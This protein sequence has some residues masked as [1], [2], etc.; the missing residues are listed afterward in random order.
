[1]GVARAR[2]PP[3]PPCNTARKSR[4]PLKSRRSASLPSPQRRAVDGSQ[5]HVERGVFVSQLS[6]AIRRLRVGAR[7]LE[8]SRIACTSEDFIFRREETARLQ[9]ASIHA[10]T[11][12]TDSRRIFYP[13]TGN[14]FRVLGLLAG[15]RGIGASTRLPMSSVLI[16]EVTG[17]PF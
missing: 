15:F 17:H 2:V 3:M 6:D 1:V 8:P 4:A 11:A 7:M 16:Q 13:K 14:R 5:S 12:Q 9:R 10:R